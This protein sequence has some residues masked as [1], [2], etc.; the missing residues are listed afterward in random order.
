MPA[1]TVFG[2][3]IDQACLFYQPVTDSAC[4]PDVQTS[5]AYYDADKFRINMHLA[6]LFRILSPILLTVSWYRSRNQIFEGDAAQK[7]QQ[8]TT[9]VDN[10]AFSRSETGLE[11]IQEE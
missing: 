4:A 1:P 2:S 10:K 9:M 6:N 8:S 7:K 5:C 11:D 3:L